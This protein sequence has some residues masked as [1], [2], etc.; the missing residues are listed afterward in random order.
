MTPEQQQLVQQDFAKLR[1]YW[2]I[3]AKDISPT[4]REWNAP[5]MAA[6]LRIEEAFAEQRERNSELERDLAAARRTDVAEREQA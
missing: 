5:Y 6:W 3:Q 2:E 1:H 4:R